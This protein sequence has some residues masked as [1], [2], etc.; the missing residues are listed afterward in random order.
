ME[1][2]EYDMWWGQGIKLFGQ[3]HL[4]W[5]FVCSICGHVQTPSDFMNIGKDPNCAYTDCIGR[6]MKKRAIALG[7]E[8]P[9]KTL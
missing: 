4:Y 8:G 5:K 7:S 3:D 9:V 2:L 1:K 6:F